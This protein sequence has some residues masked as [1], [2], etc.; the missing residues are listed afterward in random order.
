LAKQP[1]DGAT[2]RKVK[3]NDSDYPKKKL[4][5]EL[6]NLIPWQKKYF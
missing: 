4:Y 2:S 1:L 6:K 5:F 3:N